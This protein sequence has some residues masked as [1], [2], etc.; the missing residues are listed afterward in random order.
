MRTVTSTVE[1]ITVCIG[2]G[3]PAQLL[4]LDAVPIE[5]AD[6]TKII[7]ATRAAMGMSA[8]MSPKPTTRISR[9]TP[10]PRFR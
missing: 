6:E 2:L 1:T 9:K 4:G 7:T 3:K 5:G 10:A 8:T